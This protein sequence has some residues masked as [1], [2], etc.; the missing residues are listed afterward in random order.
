MT[1]PVRASVI[2]MFYIVS[3]LDQYFKTLMLSNSKQEKNNHNVR[4]N[5]VYKIYFHNHL[6]VK[7]PKVPFVNKLSILRSLDLNSFEII[8]KPFK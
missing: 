1:I 4:L 5:L 3:V 7:S 6:F 8:T 2:I